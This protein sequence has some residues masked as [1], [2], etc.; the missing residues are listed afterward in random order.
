MKTINL[1]ILILLLVIFSVGSYLLGWNYGYIKSC[2]K[3]E[4]NQD[5]L[6]SSIDSLRDENQI[7]GSYLSEYEITIGRYDI[8]YNRAC[9][10]LTKKEIEEIESNIE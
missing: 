3:A 5:A 4:S 8:L 6:R 9:Q 10:K 7:L 2:Q 1:P